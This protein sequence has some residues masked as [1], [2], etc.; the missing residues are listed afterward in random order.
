MQSRTWEMSA[1]T[2]SGEKGSTVEVQAEE[3]AASMRF[4]TVT[5]TKAKA[6]DDGQAEERE[7]TQS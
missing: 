5:I 6:E 4:A 7:P 3:V 2:E 1:E